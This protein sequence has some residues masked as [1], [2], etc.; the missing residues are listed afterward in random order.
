MSHPQ[1]TKPA[2]APTSLSVLGVKG[3]KKGPRIPGYACRR[4][5]KAAS[6]GVHNPSIPVYSGMFCS[7]HDPSWINFNPALFPGY[8]ELGIACPSQA[9]LPLWVQQCL[10]LFRHEFSLT[11]PWQKRQPWGRLRKSPPGPLKRAMAPL[12]KGVLGDT[13]QAGW[14][15]R[16]CA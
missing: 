8:S 10:T 1:W 11:R 13:G 12:V 6:P 4:A 3:Y 2:A 7:H 5:P 16:R 14:P 15:K 9:R